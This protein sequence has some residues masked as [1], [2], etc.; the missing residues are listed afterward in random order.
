MRV[1]C[2][3]LGTKYVPNASYSRCN[4]LAR[5]LYVCET[6]TRRRAANAVATSAYFSDATTLYATVVRNG[7]TTVSNAV[8]S[9]K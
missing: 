3:G 5:R 1:V 8:Y 4:I 2:T 9:R 7:R 6:W